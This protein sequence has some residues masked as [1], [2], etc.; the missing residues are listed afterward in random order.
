MKPRSLGATLLLLAVIF[1]TSWLRQHT[2]QTMPPPASTA[3]AP[4]SSAAG[5]AR[6]LNRDEQMGGHTLAKHVSRTD[7]QLRERLQREGDIS[8]ASTWTDAAVAARTVGA[9]IDYNGAKISQWL[10]RND[11]RSNLALHYHAS[12]QVGRSIRR[13]SDT[14]VPCYDATVVLRAT[15]N[16]DYYVLTAYPEAGRE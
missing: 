4:V 10:G 7:D 13:G 3:S 8:A 2:N 6:D 9:A 12:E 16:G 15:G 5:T 14:V 1:G 11:S